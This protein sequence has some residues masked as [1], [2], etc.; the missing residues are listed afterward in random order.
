MTTASFAD[1]PLWTYP[2]NHK[3]DS[4]VNNLCQLLQNPTGNILSYSTGTFTYLKTSSE[5]VTQIQ[6]AD[7]TTQTTSGSPSNL[8]WA[9]YRRPRLIYHSSQ[10]VDMEIGLDGTASDGVVLFPNGSKYT[11]SVG[12]P[13]KLVCDLTKNANNGNGV[14]QSG[15][16]PTEVLTNQSWYNFYAVISTMTGN[17]TDFILIASTFQP[18]QANYASLNTFFGTNSWVYL[19]ILPYGNGVSGSFDNNILSFR[20]SGNFT[21]FRSTATNGV[22]GPLFSNGSVTNNL[23]FYVVGTSVTVA[24]AQVTVAYMNCENGSQTTQDVGSNSLATRFGRIAGVSS[25]S[26][27]LSFFIDIEDSVA[28]AGSGVANKTLGMSGFF[29]DIL[30]TQIPFL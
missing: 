24:P 10:K 4:E 11:V 20:Q 5:T 3:L 14:Q 19:G 6:F 1:C 7:G 22:A 15:I 28:C 9:K 13:T 30:G 21:I 17:T 25:T 18:T 27:G 8:N 16:R 23:W 12:T 26:L 2:E 29:D